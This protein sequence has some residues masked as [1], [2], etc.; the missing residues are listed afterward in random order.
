MIMLSQHGWNQVRI[1]SNPVSNKAREEQHKSIQL[2]K[3]ETETSGQVKWN[4][5]KPC[6]ASKSWKKQVNSKQ[7]YVKS[8]QEQFES[9]LEQ[10]KWGSSQVKHG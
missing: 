2:Q 4:N 10:A 9:S 8:N 1:K 3:K 7:D 6:Q 5:K